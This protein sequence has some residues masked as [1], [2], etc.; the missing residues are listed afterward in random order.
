MLQRP[1]TRATAA[2]AGHWLVFIGS[3]LAGAAEVDTSEWKCEFFPFEDGAVTAD[4]EAGRDGSRTLTVSL[5]ADASDDGYREVWLIRNDAA[6]LISLGVLDGDSG[7]FVIPDGVDLDEYSIVD[8]S[9]EPIDGD[10]AHS[11]DSIV[12]GQLT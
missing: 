9:V 5:A 4:V 7:S 3:S 8:I 10:P 2:I 1:L 11:G 6:A 12:R